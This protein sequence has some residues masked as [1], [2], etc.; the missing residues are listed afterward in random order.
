MS[1]YERRRDEERRDQDR[2]PGPGH[3]TYDEKLDRWR[4]DWSC[5]LDRDLED[6]R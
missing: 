4:E 5:E 1:T 6:G 3:E 2:E